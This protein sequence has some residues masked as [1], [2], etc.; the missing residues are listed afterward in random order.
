MAPLPRRFYLLSDLHVDFRLNLAALDAAAAASSVTGDLPGARQTDVV[1]VAGDV[2]HRP[3]KC[4]SALAALQ[5]RFVGGVCFVPG[6]H[7]AF[8]PPTARKD[9]DARPNVAGNDSL[10][11]LISLC[12]RAEAA[13]IVVRPAVWRRAA[14]GGRDVWVVP[15]WGWHHPSW[16]REGVEGAE[17]GMLADAALCRWPP[18]PPP[19]PASARPSPQPPPVGGGPA[20]PSPGHPAALLDRVNIDGLPWTDDGGAPAAGA[21]GFESVASAAAAL[22][23]IRAARALG[24]SPVVLTFSH[25]L[26]LQ[27]RAW[28]Q[29]R[30][31]RRRRPQRAADPPCPPPPPTSPLQELLPPAALLRPPGLAKAMGSDAIAARVASLV[32]HCHGFGHS[33]VDV[34]RDVRHAA[35]ATGARGT[36]SAA[37]APDPGPAATRFVQRALKYPRERGA[38]GPE[39]SASASPDPGGLALAVGPARLWPPDDDGGGGGGRCGCWPRPGGAR[40]RPPGW[41]ERVAWERGGGWLTTSP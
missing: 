8:L 39:A 29:R 33:H 14:I 2:H 28:A 15:L 26:P 36:A 38:G 20:A 41:D 1:L 17:G 18:P 6:N 25:F 5:R 19:P 11:Q 27:A 31:R 22:E 35:P 32:P 12:R 7:E 9:H 23:A 21:N 16:D 10:T 13:G 3:D 40:L 24:E 30:R 37:T 4:L 34:R